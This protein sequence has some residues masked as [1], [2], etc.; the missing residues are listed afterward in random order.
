[1]AIVTSTDFG[2]L[3]KR[4]IS[5]VGSPRSAGTRT[6]H[7]CLCALSGAARA[8]RVTADLGAERA[9]GASHAIDAMRGAPRH[10]VWPTPAKSL[11]EDQ[12]RL[13]ARADRAE[14]THSLSGV[15]FA[16]VEPIN[17]DHA[18]AAD[19]RWHTDKRPQ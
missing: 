5:D 2:R 9:S 8:R 16:L 15:F 6:A 18:A 19:K 7:A 4:A 1:M 3:L 17:A 14:N 11:R 12:L 13:S 10:L